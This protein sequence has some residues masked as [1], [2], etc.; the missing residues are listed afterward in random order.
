M[1]ILIIFVIAVEQNRVPNKILD[2][3][4]DRAKKDEKSK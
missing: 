2:T 4:N 1:K 3:I